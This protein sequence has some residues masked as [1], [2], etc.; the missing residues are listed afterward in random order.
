MDIGPF[1]ELVNKGG[2]IALLA[3]NLWA[4]VGGHIVPKWVHTDIREDRD[5]WRRTALQATDN[6]D[7]ALMEAEKHYAELLRHSSQ[8]GNMRSGGT[9]TGSGSN[10]G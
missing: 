10:A 2:V 8:D 3:F 6:A 1:L 4:F 9:S 7:R 5:Q